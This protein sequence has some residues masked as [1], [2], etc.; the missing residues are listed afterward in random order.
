LNLPLARLLVGLSEHDVL[1]TI[2]EK[3][4][5]PLPRSKPAYL[6]D[7][8]MLFDPRYRLDVIR[9]FIDLSRQNGLIVK[10]CGDVDGDMLTYAEQGDDDYKRY[11]IND[12]DV[13]VVK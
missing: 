5:E 1:S 2:A 8:E 9:L 6:T 7:Y 11:K 3:I 10:W 13:T 4:R 12:Y